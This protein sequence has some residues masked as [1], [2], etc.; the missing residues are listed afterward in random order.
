MNSQ[1]WL[2]TEYPFIQG[3]M[4]HVAT[5][6][7][8]AAVSNAGGLGTI[9]TGGMTA[10]QLAEEIALCKCLTDRPFAVNVLMIH[11]EIEKI[12]DVVTQAQVPFVTTGA[13]NPAEY[14]ARWQA[15]GIRVMPVVGSAVMA[16]RMEKIG[17]DAII[18]EGQEAGGHI[19]ALST[20]VLLPQVAQAVSVPV[21]G[22]GGIATGE[23]VL[24]AEALGAC[25]IQMGTRLLLSEECP[26]HPAYKERLRKAKS[27]QVTVIGRIGGMPTRVLQNDMTR[28]YIEAEKS[29]A[30][31]ETLEKFTLSA[32]RRA[33]HD[34]DILEGSVMCGDVVGAIDDV[35]PLADLFAALWK[36]YKERR[37]NLCAQ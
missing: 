34:G 16:R 33:V 25:G 24:A 5:G 26:V 19:G 11:W 20:M 1:K 4:A 30:D 2:G 9:G 12:A 37:K 35:V 23:Q 28:R 6:R 36:D 13:G 7:F 21:I 14:M 29:G 15:A 22:A 18:C 27:S 31:M 8:A 10:D 17:A 3:G 32:L